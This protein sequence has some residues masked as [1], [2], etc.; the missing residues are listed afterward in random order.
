MNRFAEANNVDFT[1]VQA[2]GIGAFESLTLL[3]SAIGALEFG[4]TYTTILCEI[5]MTAA[6]VEMVNL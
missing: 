6:F 2:G 3:L 1:Q 5:I 4:F